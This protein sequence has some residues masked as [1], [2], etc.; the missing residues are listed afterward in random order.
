MRKYCIRHGKVIW[1]CQLWHANICSVMCIK[2]VSSDTRSFHLNIN[3]SSQFPGSVRVLYLRISGVGIMSVG[4][5]M[6]ETYFG[7]TRF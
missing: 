1:Y 3:S 6:V 2:A 4:C 7:R 5:F